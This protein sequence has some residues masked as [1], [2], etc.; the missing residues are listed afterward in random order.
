MKSHQIICGFNNSILRKYRYS[1]TSSFWPGQFWKF[2]SNQIRQFLQFQSSHK[3]VKATK[4]LVFGCRI[5]FLKE[6]DIFH[7]VFSANF[8]TVPIIPQERQSYQ[9]VG[10]WPQNLLLEKMRHFSRCFFGEFFHSSNHPTRVSKLSNYWSM[11]A[12]FISWNNETFFALFFR[13]FTVPIIPQEC[14]SYQIVGLSPQ[15]LF[16]EK[17]KLYLRCF[18]LFCFNLQK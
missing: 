12:E 9:I 1:T 4:L 17:M 18:S 16:L 14:Q 2:S 8:F 10:L 5:Y 13:L 11:A 7:V 15:N 6:W 3:S